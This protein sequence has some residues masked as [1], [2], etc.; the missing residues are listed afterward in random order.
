MRGRI[1]LFVVIVLC[2]LSTDSAQTQESGGKLRTKVTDA[3]NAAAKGKCP[4]TILG[5]LVLDACEQQITRMQPALARLGA[6]KDLRYRGV[7][8]LPTGVEVE[9]YRV[10][11][12]NGEM[13]WMVAA[14]PNGK[15]TVL[16]SPG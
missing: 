9:V 2:A 16:Y 13:L 6:I 15:L 10:V 12:A 4:D 8:Q 3:L 11:F 1:G 5:P 14:G 7:E